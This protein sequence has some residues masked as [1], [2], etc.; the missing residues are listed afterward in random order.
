MTAAAA[1]ALTSLVAGNAQAQAAAHNV[2]ALPKLIRWGVA[3]KKP[4]CYYLLGA[5]LH[6]SLSCLGTSLLSVKTPQQYQFFDVDIKPA[7]AVNTFNHLRRC[8]I[9]SCSA[10]MPSLHSRVLAVA[11]PETDPFG[12]QSV[13]H[14][15]NWFFLMSVQFLVPDSILCN[16]QTNKNTLIMVTIEE[17]LLMSD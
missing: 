4:S 6:I 17:V 2:G 11:T 1:A 15:W 9:E 10:V 3:E 5:F 12:K 8:S 16:I 13:G 14:K 7:A